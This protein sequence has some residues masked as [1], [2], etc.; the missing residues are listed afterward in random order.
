MNGD[1]VN[2]K[3]ETRRPDEDNLQSPTAAEDANPRKPGFLPEV[4]DKTVI[5]AP[6][7]EEFRKQK[8]VYSIIID[9]NLL[10]HAGRE[11]AKGE[12]QRLV[13]DIL[14]EFPDKNE[15]QG[16][17]TIKTKFSK[18]Y[19]FAVLQEEVIKELVRSDRARENP[20]NKQ[21]S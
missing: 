12:V 7:F 6:L 18:Q 13:V 19:V 16:I 1:Q 14:K 11:A 21:P 5:T 10:Y 4:L 9:V 17:H 20:D 3:S 8:K 15:G 2:E